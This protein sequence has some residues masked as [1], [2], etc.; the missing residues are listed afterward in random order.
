MATPKS[1]ATRKL[2]EALKA[3]RGRQI[4]RQNVA[5]A[6]GIHLTNYGEYERGEREIG[7]H[8]LIRIAY[9]LGTT[10]SE[11]LSGIDAHDVPGFDTLPTAQQTRDEWDHRRKLIRDAQSATR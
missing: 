8:M 3:A 1:D 7:L 6:A 2:G 11:L 4:S 10:P 5:D 9:V